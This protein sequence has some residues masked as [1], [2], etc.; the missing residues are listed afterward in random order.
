MTHPVLIRLEELVNLL[1]E[2]MRSR[3][4]G[5]GADL[6]NAAREYAEACATVNARLQTC[7]D[8]LG[9]GRDK[10]HQ[11]LM[12]ATRQ[13]DLLD[14]CSVLSELQ[15]DDYAAFCRRNHLP[16]APLLNERAKQEIDPLY[17]RAG[18]FQKKLR[19]EFSA[20]NS[21]RDFREALE[22][23]RQ[24]TRVDPSDV[25]T[26]KQ[27]AALEDRLVR[28]VISG[29]IAPALDKGDDEVAV[30]ALAEIEAIAP[31]RQ[32]R[33]GERSEQPWHEAI[34]VR[35]AIEKDEAVRT[36]GMLLNQ[37]VS[38]R[39]ADNL[40]SV[41]EIL[42]R[43]GGQMERHS[44]ELP[45]ESAHLYSEL[46][47]WRDERLR[48]ARI[49]SDFQD[50]LDELRV[51][52]KQVA[53]KEFRNTVPGY[54]ENRAD[55]LELQRVWKEIAEFRKPVDDELQEKARKLLGDL[56]AKID[57]NERARRRN[58]IVVGAA[59]L[60]ALVA[61]IVVAMMFLK[62]GD[63]AGQ[64]LSAQ[65][66]G[67]AGDLVKLLDSLE[68][69][70]PSWRS[71]G[72]LP[73]VESNAR[74]WLGEEQANAARLHAMLSTIR[75][76]FGSRPQPLDWTP[77]SLG[78]VKTRL[79]EI[80]AEVGKVNRDD[81][82]PLDDA[83]ASLSTSWSGIADTVRNTIVEEF[84]AKVGD[85][86]RA[87]REELGSDVAL[88]KALARVGSVNAQIAELDTLAA[89]EIDELKPS[90]A[91]VTRFGVLK[92]RVATISADLN[93]V[94]MI[95]QKCAEADR[96]QTYVE[97]VRGLQQTPFLSA[98]QKLALADL[99]G[100]ADSEER[101][102][103]E[104]LMP[105]DVVKWKSLSERTIAADGYPND[106]TPDE[107]AVFLELRDDKSLSEVYL[108]RITEGRKSRTI[109]SRGATLESADVSTGGSLIS[110]MRGSEVYDP[111]GASLNTVSFSERRYRIE[112]GPNFTR[113]SLPTGG[114]LAPESAFFE[115]LGLPGYVKEDFSAFSRSGLELAEKIVKAP[116]T[117]SPLF[118]AY[119]F[120]RVG[121]LMS[122]RPEKWLVDYCQFGE[123]LET[124]RSIA[125][126]AM[127]G[128]DWCSTEKN[129]AV[130]NELRA[131]FAERK[132]PDYLDRAKAVHGFH[133]RLVTGGVV[134]SGHLDHEGRI[135]TPR[136]VDVATILWGFDGSLRI[137]PLF[138]KNAAGEWKPV[139][140]AA[141]F[142]PLFHLRVNPEITWE[143]VAKANSVDPSDESLT[144]RLPAVL[145][146]GAKPE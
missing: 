107:E 96:L 3:E 34:A 11:A 42:A 106:I 142:T 67:R 14:A 102:L 105:G 9:K 121:K 86:D 70:P 21:K 5:S 48:K 1:A 75:D 89:V 51:L 124:I 115:T 68:K 77:V 92:E 79:D 140:P 85:L 110:E 131:F 90:A 7:L 59:G 112:R 87:V 143:E 39:D 52:I 103:R 94:S 12:A 97:A 44:F 50:R 22:I 33:A 58:L 130:A 132:N 111:D 41:L 62:A 6:V 37:A 88:G 81:R 38:A 98:A 100:V 137:A 74:T 55:A 13:P 83:L 18:S 125:G 56:N 31:G 54:D 108:Y 32:P 35:K 126:A 15:T 47:Q 80:A 119:L 146:I 8:I 25:A 43:I 133:A 118:R 145:G 46:C 4:E 16:T 129:A 91:D 136:P 78:A 27:A 66:D 104:I 82:I 76:E 53:D 71:F 109:Y 30:A 65:E 72:K 60:A 116:D 113:G 61:A 128:A 93:Q 95:L 139:N 28:E 141:E 19:M 73:R 63:L 20:A 40:E 127:T 26:A 69:E 120:L 134:F 29:R 114:T 64:L 2:G 10:E 24:L 117:I 99:L 135:R 57:R 101:V 45:G 23:A 84:H 144:R 122:S 138:R 36:S 123:D 17:A 49:E